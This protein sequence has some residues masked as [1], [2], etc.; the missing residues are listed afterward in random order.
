MQKRWL[1]LIGVIAFFLVLGIGAAAGGAV[2][3][4][5]LRDDV[6]AVIAAPS[7][8]AEEEGIII[9]F[10]EDNS[11][12]AKAGLERGD[13]LLAVEGD[14]VNSFFELMEIL[15]DKNPGDAVELTVLHGDETRTLTANLDENQEDAFLGVWSCMGMGGIHKEVIIEGGP[16]GYEKEFEKEIEIV[17]TTGA[18]I[19]EVVAD[20][21]AAAAGLEA[22]DIILSVAGEELGPRTDLTDLILAHDPGDAVILLI[23][24]ADEEFETEVTLGEHPDKD[25]QAFLGVGYEPAMPHMMFEGEDFFFHDGPHDM[26]HHFGGPG[27]PG[28][29]EL[30]EFPAGVER[31]VIIGDV[32]D[33]TPA[34]K[35]GLRVDDLIIFVAGK[36]VEDFD[37]FVADVQSY[38]PGDDVDFTLLRNG[39]ELELTITLMEHPD[40][41]DNGYLGVKVTGLITITIEGEMPNFEKDIEKELQLPGGDA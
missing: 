12:A 13:I 9:S 7:G 3:Y 21:P 24:R 16:F 33:G 30:N 17:V 31:A 36:S 35:A 28:F 38:N 39:E 27:M 34:D 20:S 4:F 37:S 29:P 23:A 19:S 2:A 11:A 25:G 5:M 26:P 40:D 18:R 15:A 14:N 6:T 1:I 22:G 41:P 8:E 10:V 32:M